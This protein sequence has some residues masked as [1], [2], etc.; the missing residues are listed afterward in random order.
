M[1]IPVEVMVAMQV[2]LTVGQE[3]GV[4]MRSILAFLCMR[5]G[6]CL[7]T[8]EPALWLKPYRLQPG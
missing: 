8:N 6:R 5:K 4:Y 2:C 3:P 7:A 1:H